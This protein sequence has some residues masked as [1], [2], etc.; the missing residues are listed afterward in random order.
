[1]ALKRIYMPEYIMELN[2]NQT[3]YQMFKDKEGKPYID[4]PESLEHVLIEQAAKMGAASVQEQP[5]EP[6]TGS[7]IPAV[8]PLPE[9]EADTTT[10]AMNSADVKA[11]ILTATDATALQKLRAGELMHPQYD[12]GRSGVIAAI[13]ARISELES[14]GA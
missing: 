3:V 2:L 4:I 11:L 7:N 9:G 8:P 13:D 5:A 10:H 6:A 1:M 14:A 12:G